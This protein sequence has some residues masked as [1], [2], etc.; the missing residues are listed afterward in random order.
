MM[1]RKNIYYY[2]NLD[3]ILIFTFNVKVLSKRVVTAM[4]YFINK[5]LILSD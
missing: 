3:T 2:P 5:K 1:A 4:D